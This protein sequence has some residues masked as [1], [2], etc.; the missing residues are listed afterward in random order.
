MN[1]LLKEKTFY[2]PLDM[3]TVHP[4][5]FECVQ[6]HRWRTK[7]SFLSLP[8][9]IDNDTISIKKVVHSFSLAKIPRKVRCNAKHE[10][11]SRRP[12]A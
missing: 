10:I 7:M 5:N 4:E 2:D 6:W 9:S 11:N 3:C 8:C 12:K 1:Q